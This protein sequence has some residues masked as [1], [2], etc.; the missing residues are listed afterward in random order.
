MT[1]LRAILSGGLCTLMLIL[2]PPLIAATQADKDVYS[3]DDL[4]MKELLVYPL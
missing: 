2:H 3:F 4:P 1:K